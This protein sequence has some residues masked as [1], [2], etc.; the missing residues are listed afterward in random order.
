MEVSG[1]QYT[2]SHN[3]E[4]DC[5]DVF[6]GN[7]VD[8]EQAGRKFVSLRV[9]GRDEEQGWTFRGERHLCGQDTYDVTYVMAFRGLAL[10]RIVINIEVTGPFKDYTSHTTLTRT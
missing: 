1:S 5:I 10:T 2:F 8:E 7:K 9:A 4:D 3:E 6:F